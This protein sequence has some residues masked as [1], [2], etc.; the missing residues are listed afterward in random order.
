M[1]RMPSGSIWSQATF[2]HSRLTCHR[3]QITNQLIVNCLLPM[4]AP[5]GQQSSL[6]SP[7]VSRDPG[8]ASW[9]CGHGSCTS[10]Q[11]Q[12]RLT[13]ESDSLWLPSWTPDH[14]TFEFRLR[15]WHLLGQRG[16][17]RAMEP[18]SWALPPFHTPSVPRIGAGPAVPCPS[19]SLCQAPIPEASQIGHGGSC[20]T[21]G[22]QCNSTIRH[23]SV[24][25]GT[26]S[27]HSPI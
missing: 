10:S 25:A 21:Q 27:C 8:M 19:E 14:F 6:K 1:Y 15:M 9:A 18:Y 22:W 5:R 16:W 23:N 26:E 3:F 11:A 4:L 17:S 20:V 13:V 24:A 2:M 7:S 12:K